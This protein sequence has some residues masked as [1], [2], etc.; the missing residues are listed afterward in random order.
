LSATSF[1]GVRIDSRW[2]AGARHQGK[3]AHSFGIVGSDYRVGR[4][5]LW[6]VSKVPDDATSRTNFNNAVIKLIGNK[7]VAWVVE[8]AG[9]GRDSGR[10]ENEGDTE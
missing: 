10:A 3:F 5:I 9:G 4:E 7:N 1:W 6:T 8:F 2:Y